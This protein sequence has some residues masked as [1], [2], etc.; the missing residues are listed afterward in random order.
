MRAPDLLLASAQVRRFQCP[1]P[2]CGANLVQKP[3]LP[4]EILDLARASRLED[5]LEWEAEQTPAEQIPSQGTDRFAQIDARDFPRTVQDGPGLGFAGKGP[6]DW[7]CSWSDD[8][9]GALS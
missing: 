4:Y 6:A 1:R 7:L 9:E 5:G 3:T 8:S 2:G